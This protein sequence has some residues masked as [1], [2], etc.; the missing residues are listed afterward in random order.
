[1]F[2]SMNGCMNMT[3]SPD[4]KSRKALCALGLELLPPYRGIDL[5]QHKS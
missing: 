3:D 2:L 5:E 1:M 4:M